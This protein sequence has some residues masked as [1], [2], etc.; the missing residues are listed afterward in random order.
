[1]VIPC[2]SVHREQARGGNCQQKAGGDREKQ[3]G[4]FHRLIVCL[5]FKTKT[6]RLRLSFKQ[7]NFEKWPD[8]L[9]NL[10]AIEANAVGA[11]GVK[12]LRVG[13]GGG[14]DRAIAPP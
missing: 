12:V 10:D 4:F 3:Y 7:I 1:M 2:R 9:K 5:I 13:A 11:A 8:L 6:T 14:D